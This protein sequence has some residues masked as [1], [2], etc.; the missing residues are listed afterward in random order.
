M[1]AIPSFQLS[2]V[3]GPPREFSAA[4]WY[5]A[6]T[7]PRHEKRV[8]EEL[9]RKAVEI[10]LPVYE[11]MRK[12]KNGRHRIQL[13]LFPGYAFV[14]ISLNDRLNVLR[15]PGVVNLVGANG[16]PIALQESELTN[17]RQA[18]SIGTLAKPHPFLTEG[19]RV[20][21][22]SGPFAGLEGLLK[23]RKGQAGVV[24]SLILIQRSVLVEVDS[25]ELEPIR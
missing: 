25:A 16:T 8:A 2:T 13:P 3:M 7:R 4:H 12:W 21:V 11:T 14:R 17:L 20:R 9:E 6:Y 24:V 18:L 10:F 22:T 19:R 1:V 15:V 5:A 23:R